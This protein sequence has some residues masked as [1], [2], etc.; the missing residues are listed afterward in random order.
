MAVGARDNIDRLLVQEYS[1]KVTLCT[2][3]STTAVDAEDMLTA[4]Q[5]YA[6]MRMT[7][8]NMRDKL[9]NLCSNV[10]AKAACYRSST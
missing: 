8:L 2:V 10:S 3:E 1:D 6:S 5:D 7:M 9:K 4:M